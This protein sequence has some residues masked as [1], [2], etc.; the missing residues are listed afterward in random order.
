MLEALRNGD[1]HPA[2]FFGGLY[3]VFI[4]V[5][6]LVIN[7]VMAKTKGYSWKMAVILAFVPFFDIVFSLIYLG[8]PKKEKE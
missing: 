1:I 4:F 7:L 8:L 5:S 3:F 6:C 2:H